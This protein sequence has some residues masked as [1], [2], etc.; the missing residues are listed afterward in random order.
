MYNGDAPEN[1]PHRPGPGKATVQRLRCRSVSLPL[2]YITLH[3]IT[4][5]YITL[6][7][8]TLIFAADVAEGG[9][10]LNQHLLFAGMEVHTARRR[11]MCLYVFLV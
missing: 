10:V 11:Y 3:Y 1:T 7:Y 9:R 2:H 4:L 8:I 5:H 6:H